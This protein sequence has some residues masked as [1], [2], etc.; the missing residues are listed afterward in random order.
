MEMHLFQSIIEPD[1]KIEAMVDE[2]TTLIRKRALGICFRSVFPDSSELSAF[3]CCLVELN[4]MSA[5][6]VLDLM[7]SC[8]HKHGFT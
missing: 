7:L 1:L 2:S 3:F 8:L 4:N 6:P 5:L